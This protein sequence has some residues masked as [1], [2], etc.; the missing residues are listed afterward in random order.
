MVKKVVH[1]ACK[2]CNILKETN[3]F[4]KDKSYKSGYRSTCIECREKSFKV[5]NDNDLILKI[6]E[7]YLELCSF[8]KIANKFGLSEATIANYCK[9][10]ILLKPKKSSEHKDNVRKI[11]VEKN[12]DKDK[13]YRKEY[14]KKYYENNKTNILIYQNNY[15]K[16]RRQIDPIYKFR[17]RMGIM[18]CGLFRYHGFKKKNKT[19]EIL[20]CSFEEFKVYLESKFEP[21]MNWDNKG[22]YNGKFSYGW[23]VD[24]IIPLATA[25]TEEDIIR[26]NHYTNLQPLCSKINRDIK[27]DNLSYY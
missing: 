22:L 1:L 25:E 21:W 16:K 26:L 17:Y 27:I 6:R 10:L 8:R 19:T 24:H 11:W 12:I 23:D 13:E 20:G 9:D 5:I 18:L 7:S 15:K 2:K 14:G 3:M 4:H